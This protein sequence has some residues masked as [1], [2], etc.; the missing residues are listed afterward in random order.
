M[1]DNLRAAGLYLRGGFRVEGVRH[2]AVLGDGAA[3]D[4][5]YMGKL[6]PAQDGI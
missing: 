3:I 1:A 5:Y 2:R 6:L 4:E